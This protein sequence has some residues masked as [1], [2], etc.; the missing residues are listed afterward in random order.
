MAPSGLTS[1]ARPAGTNADLDALIQRA[2]VRRA[3]TL[4]HRPGR[5]CELP[6]FL[7][8][9][10]IIGRIDVVDPSRPDELNLDDR[11]LV[12]CPN[13]M[14]VFCR[15]REE[16]PAL[17]NSPVLSAFSPIPKSDTPADHGDGFCIGVSVRRDEVVGRE[18]DA[19]D[20]YPA[21]FCRIAYQDGDL[22]ALWNGRIVLPCQRLRRG[23]GTLSCAHAEAHQCDHR[24]REK[25]RFHRYPPVFEGSY[26]HANA[27]RIVGGCHATPAP[28]IRKS[29][30]RRAN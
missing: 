30:V 10:R 18:L 22:A 20:Y 4:H 28:A 1:G 19:L 25:K 24:R 17:A 9:A 29:E 11:R 23:R 14:S 2:S 15:V 5:S 6:G 8:L 16:A 12:S 7:F 13:I 21:S 26:A 3:G 27:R